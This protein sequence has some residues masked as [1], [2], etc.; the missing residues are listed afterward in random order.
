MTHQRSLRGTCAHRKESRRP[1]ATSERGRGRGHRYERYSELSPDHA[2][3]QSSPG[4]RHYA[5]HG[6]EAIQRLTRLCFARMLPRYLIGWM[7]DDLI[8]VILMATEMLLVY[9]A[10]ALGVDFV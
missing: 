3:L 7:G 2:A 9:I 5:W 4:S 1:W 10:N 8:L 6:H